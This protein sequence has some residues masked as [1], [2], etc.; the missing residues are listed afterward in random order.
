M[1]Q[2][3]NID[4]LLKLYPELS[5]KLDTLFP[6]CKTF[7]SP[8]F[9]DIQAKNKGYT[10][11]TLP[12][13]NTYLSKLIEMVEYPILFEIYKNDVYDYENLQVSI[14]L[15]I[16]VRKGDTSYEYIRVYPQLEDKRKGWAFRGNKNNYGI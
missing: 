7:Y 11:K 3:D 4:V 8:C 9:I 2:M 15:T 10:Q 14:P 1:S 16:A 13:C 5:T 12:D 6:E